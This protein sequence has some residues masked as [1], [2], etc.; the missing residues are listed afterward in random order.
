MALPLLLAAWSPAVLSQTPVPPAPEGPTYEVVS[1]KA[2]TSTTFNSSVT[3]RPDGG[4][5]ALNLPVGALIARAYPPAIPA[6]IVGLPDWGMRD[7]YDVTATSTRPNVTP[8]DRVAMLRALLADRFTLAAHMENRQREVYDLVLARSDGRLGTGITPLD[9]DCAAQ[10]A[11]AQAARAGGAPPPP[12]PPPPTVL[13]PLTAGGPP[14]VQYATPPEPCMLR[15]ANENLEGQGMVADLLTLFRAAT[16]REVVDRTGLT[17]SYQVTMRFD[18]AASRRGPE[19][20]AASP[21][22]APSVFTAVQ[23]QLGMKLQSARVERPTLVI[24]R[25]ER[26]T[27]N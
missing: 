26:P 27:E 13:P 21:D 15:M 11:A 18:P 2:N 22:A 19:T 4:L 24:D 20:I 6:D 12:P 9:V 14:R 25:L 10:R 8:D 17:G 23:E 7:R 16:G 1:V 3:Q 5:T